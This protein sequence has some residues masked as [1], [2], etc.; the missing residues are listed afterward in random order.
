M[1]STGVLL[2]KTESRKGARGS[3]FGLLLFALLCLALSWPLLFGEYQFKVQFDVWQTPEIR[4]L[5]QINERKQAQS[6]GELLGARSNV[7]GGVKWHGSVPPW[8]KDGREK[9]GGCAGGLN[10]QDCQEDGAIVGRALSERLQGVTGGAQ[11]TCQVDNSACKGEKEKL[12]VFVYE[13]PAN[14]SD[15]FYKHPSATVRF[16]AQK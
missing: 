6:E 1:Q 11:A 9:L 5:K 10:G 3:R 7:P 4:F 15:N 14:M 8:R 16:E 2:G 12:R 13:L